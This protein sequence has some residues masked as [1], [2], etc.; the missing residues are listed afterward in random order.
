MSL[1]LALLVV[2]VANVAQAQV[3]YGSLVGTVND[4]SGA[5]VGAA[6]ITA[7]NKQTGVKR[8]ATTK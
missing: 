4:Q 1:L 2:A 7:T 5:A 3:F 8:Q 6:S